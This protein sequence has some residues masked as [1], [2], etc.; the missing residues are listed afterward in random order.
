MVTALLESPLGE[1]LLIFN[2]FPNST[3]TS[4]SSP[5]FSQTYRKH[6]LQR[7][8]RTEIQGVGY[9]TNMPSIKIY[10]V[11]IAIYIAFKLYEILAIARVL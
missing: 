10:Q 7:A 2:L 5:A 4:P 6:D 9:V 11:Y 8:L 1:E 3:D